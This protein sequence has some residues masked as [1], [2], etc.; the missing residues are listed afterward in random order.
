VT[1]VPK[2]GEELVESETLVQVPPLQKLWGK[3]IATPQL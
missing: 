3:S 2:K 1:L